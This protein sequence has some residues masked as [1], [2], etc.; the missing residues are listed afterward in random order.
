MKRTALLIALLAS[1]AGV[2]A[3]SAETTIG[4]FTIVDGDL[5]VL[6]G[7]RAFPA[8]EGLRLHNDDIV[9]SG[10]AARLARIELTD[11]TVL[12]LGPQTELLLQP[13]VLAQ[14]SERAAALYLLRGWLKISSAIDPAGAGFAFASP[15]F[16]IT[17]LAGSVVVR[18]LPQSSLVF[19]ETGRGELVERSTGKAGPVHALNGGDTF[20]AYAASPGALLRRPPPE[21][22]E[23][24]PR[25]FA[26]S[27]PRRAPLFKATV[28]EAPSGTELGY[29][30]I[31]P[32]IHAEAVLRPGFVRRFGALAR[33]RQLRASLVAELRSHPEWNRVLFPDKVR[34]RPVVAKLK[35]LPPGVQPLPASWLDA[36]EPALASAPVA[37]LR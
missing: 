21:L 37:Q 19:V 9:R 14:P 15:Q 24:L 33:D 16:D 22:I 17:G 8:V 23:G 3:H 28:V 1:L 30:D 12:D 26:D 7:T 27:L 2:P 5:V 11:G 18:A 10:A 35:P 32:W 25:G 6:R 31:S 13:Q 34:P 29:A 20:A 36:V 4:M